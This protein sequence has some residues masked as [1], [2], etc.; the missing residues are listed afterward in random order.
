MNQTK[1][2]KNFF[3]SQYFSDGLRISLGVLLPSLLFALAGHLE[4]GSTLS[5]GAIAVSIPDNP[6]AVIYKRNAM[7]AA[8]IAMAAVS[9]FT[10][11]TSNSVWLLGPAIFLMC[12]FFSMFNLYGQRAA[13]LA[14]GSLVIMVVNIERTIP[15]TELLI[16]TGYLVAGGVW[17]MGLSLAVSSFRPYRVAQNTLGECINEIADYLK[18]KASFYDSS[19]DLDTIYK[20]LIEKQIIV[21][22]TLDSVRELLFKD[23]LLTRDQSNTARL[24]VLVFIDMVD[25]FEKTTITH[26]DYYAIRER[27][28]DTPVLAVFQKCICTIAD[29]LDDLGD[30]INM[31]ERPRIRRD[32]QIQL[33][34][35][36]TEIDKVDNNFILKKILINVRN[37]VTRINTIYSYFSNKAIKSIDISNEKDLGRFVSSQQRL[38]PKIFVENLSL[39]SNIFRHSLR[40]AI[41]CLFGFIVSKLLPL[42]HHSYWILLTLTV[43]LKPGFSLTK[44][45]NYERVIGTVIGGIA[46][47]LIVHFIGDIGVRFAFLIIFMLGAYSFQRI[48]YVVSVLFLTPYIIISFSF[49]GMATIGLAGERIIDTLIGA[50]IAFAAS[51]FLFPNWEYPQLRKVMR[52]TLMA[53]YQYLRKLADRLSGNTID[54]MEYK[55]IRKDV[56]VSTANISSSFQRMLSEP[57][58]KQR[59]VRNISKFIVLNHK[60]SSYTATILAIADQG[61]Y[62]INAQQ[63][64]EVRKALFILWEGIVLLQEPNEEEF[65]EPEIIFPPN[66]ANIEDEQSD[67]RLI[68]EQLILLEKTAGD[69]LRVC[70]DV[71]INNEQA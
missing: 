49:L 13:N 63:V 60:L 32:L 55:L 53:N 52:Q 4:I 70:Q 3:F 6:G 19:K 14:T 31:N 27:Y 66:K 16:N 10:G 59:N 35:L 15:F 58:S 33:E 67:Q 61:N 24:M 54:Q 5:L 47:A 11:I 37:I 41:V 9:I 62:Q 43:L 48:N 2:I 44:Q 64:K 65:T 50:L 56:Y 42:G 22:Q 23:K 30:D 12:F 29:Q 39:K 38:D 28:K 36:K 40:V 25:L 46:G 51:Y 69:I 21:N 57:K 45:R 20:N 26:Y 18:A 68:T 17:Y 34:E 8:I 1:E 71:N 7:I